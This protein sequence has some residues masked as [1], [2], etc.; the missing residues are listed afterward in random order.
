[1]KKIFILA[2]CAMM[3][4]MVSCSLKSQEKSS[5]ENNK[6]QADNPLMRPSTLPFQAP[7]FTKIKNSDFA[8]AFEEGIKR[9]RTEIEQIANNPEEPT[10][11]NTLGGA[12]KKWRNC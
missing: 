3:I 5:M 7:D 11:E 10:F 8:P 9:Q 6:A 2:S 12:G 4:F 1:M